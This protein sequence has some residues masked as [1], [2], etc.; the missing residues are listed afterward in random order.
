M[1]YTYILRCDDD[2]LYTGM[3][4][5]VENRLEKHISGKGAKY[6]KSHRV[7]RLE[8]YWSSKTKSLA[9]KLE[10][11]IKKLTKQQKENL[12]QGEKLSKYLSGKIDCRRYR[13][14]INTQK[15]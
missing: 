3:T 8:T 11:Q 13:N 10:Y 9:C 12:I 4:D 6:T 2:S 7:Y 1:Y 15:F 14:C 5:N